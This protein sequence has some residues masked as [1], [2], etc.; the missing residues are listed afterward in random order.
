MCR[1]RFFYTAT[2]RRGP[3]TRTYVLS[4]VFQ[5]DRH[6]RFVRVFTEPAAG[7]ATSSPDPGP[8]KLVT[9]EGH[10]SHAQHCSSKI[11]NNNLGEMG[12]GP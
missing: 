4:E 1:N 8:V 11:V 12:D 2:W 5:T 9:K 6:F 3:H 7:T 10:R